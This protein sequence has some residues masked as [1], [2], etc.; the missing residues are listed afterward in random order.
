M[1]AHVAGRVVSGSAIGAT[2]GSLEIVGTFSRVNNAIA[3]LGN[4]VTTYTSPGCPGTANFILLKSGVPGVSDT[5]AV[6]VTGIAGGGLCDWHSTCC[7]TI[8]S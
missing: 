3:P 8:A 5:V 1:S 4:A 2:G 7:S 6:E